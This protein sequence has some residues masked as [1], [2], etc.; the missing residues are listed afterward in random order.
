[1]V[2]ENVVVR[3]LKPVTAIL[4][5][6]F[7][8]PGFFAISHCLAQKG[9][10]ATQYKPTCPMIATSGI[11]NSDRITAIPRSGSSCCQLSSLLPGHKP[12][13]VTPRA[14]VTGNIVA[15]GNA[16]HT[17]L[18]PPRQATVIEVAT[19]LPTSSHLALLCVLLV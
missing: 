5:L 1:V 13:A 18:S 9:L 19:P 6:T 11:A 4:M 10:E 14:K 12:A 17:N 3:L 15:V 8:A 16:R 7:V 2:L